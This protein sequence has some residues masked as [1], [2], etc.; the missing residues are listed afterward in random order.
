M[1]PNDRLL[2]R[3]KITDFKCYSAINM[4]AIEY[5][6]H[7]FAFTQS[8]NIVLMYRPYCRFNRHSAFNK[9]RN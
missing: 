3:T 5:R 9:R 6:D 7:K 2:Q 4:S 1:K 8:P